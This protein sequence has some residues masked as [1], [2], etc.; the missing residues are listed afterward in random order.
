MLWWVWGVVGGGRGWARCAAR[1]PLAD[2][3]LRAKIVTAPILHIKIRK[4]GGKGGENM[5]NM[6]IFISFIIFH[7]IRTQAA[8]PTPVGK[9]VTHPARVGTE[10]KNFAR[11][12]YAQISNIIRV[13]QFPPG[14]MP[15]PFSLCIS[16]V[17]TR[18]LMYFDVFWYHF[19]VFFHFKK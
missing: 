2:F 1:A 15:T 11:A 5:K 18:I 7:R 13:L 3:P 14:V 8:R 4:T 16:M 10:E 9:F 17:Q 6:K 12:F 19:T